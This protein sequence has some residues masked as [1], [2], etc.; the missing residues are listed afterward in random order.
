MS[1]VT[2][3]PGASAIT[4]RAPS[5]DAAPRVPGWQR[6]EPSWHER[7]G[8]AIVYGVR[9]PLRAFNP[10]WGNLHVYTELWR[11]SMAAKGI[12]AMLA[13]WLGPPGGGGKTP[14]AFVPTAFTRFSTP[15]SKGVDAY[16][17]AQ[18]AIGN[19]AL[20][21]LLIQIGKLASSEAL[22]WGVLIASGL[23]TQGALLEGARWA[24]AAETARLV[25]VC[26]ADVM[27]PS[28]FGVAFTA[29]ERIGFVLTAT[30]FL[31]WLWRFAPSGDRGHLVRA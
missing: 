27:A 20:V 2:S 10:V 31:I 11:A 22:V 7:A 1:I 14:A 19:L 8:E 9:T 15:R 17:V 28:V 21:A 16:V 4:R 26:G 23:L 29:P 5:A 13:V 18:Y 30:M 3:P 12:K 24:R 6:C 25:V